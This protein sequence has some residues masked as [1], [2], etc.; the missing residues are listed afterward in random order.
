MNRSYAFQTTLE[1]YGVGDYEEYR[2]PALAVTDKQTVVTAYEARKEAGNDW[3]ETDIAVRRSVDG[4]KSFETP[5]FPGSTLKNIFPDAVTFNN[6]VLTAD[7]ERLHLIFCLDYARVFYCCSDDEGV[8][9]SVPREIT[10][11]FNGFHWDWNVCAAG[12]GHGIVTGSGRMLVP[13]WL[14][15][16][17]IRDETGRVKNH[18]PSRAAC[19][20]SDDH[21]ESWKR[22]T[23]AE[24]IENASETTVAEL[25]DGRIL[26]NFRN[27]RYEKCRVLGIWDT[28]MD[29][30]SEVWTELGLVDPTCFGSMAS[31]GGEI[32]FVNCANRDPARLYGP[33]L[34]L[35]VYRSTDPHHWV[36]EFLADARGGYS[37]IGV[38]E[39]GIWVFYEKGNTVEGKNI[40][41]ELVVKKWDF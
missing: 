41:G 1:R 31:Y 29:H 30:L 20:Y 28:C 14:A 2:I 13:V 9:F 36:P 10:E 6:P 27:E 38:N 40:V 18:F 22:G 37:D 34:N 33:R 24:G 21:G 3:A 5:C 19:I 23:M 25:K 32:F 4:G 8:S 11:C 17:E 12:P 7:G 26:F 16:G 35:T 39:H 15:K